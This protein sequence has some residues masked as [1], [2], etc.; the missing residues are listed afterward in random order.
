MNTELIPAVQQDHA[1][2]VGLSPAQLDR[3]L[4][5]LL[6]LKAHPEGHVHMTAEPVAQSRGVVD[7]MFFVESD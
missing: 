6:W 2:Q 1:L 7:Q 5:K 3:L 4:D